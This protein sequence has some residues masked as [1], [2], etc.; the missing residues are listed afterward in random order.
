MDDDLNGISPMRDPKFK[1]TV[2]KLSVEGGAV[3][4]M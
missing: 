4:P 1:L 2:I 3:L